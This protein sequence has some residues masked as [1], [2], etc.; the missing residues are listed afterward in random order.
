MVF[1]TKHF[2]KKNVTQPE[3]LKGHFPASI[4]LKQFFPDGFPREWKSSHKIFPAKCSS[5]H[6]TPYYPTDAARKKSCHEHSVQWYFQIPSQTDHPAGK[7][8][9]QDMTIREYKLNIRKISINLNSVRETTGRRKRTTAE[10]ASQLLQVL[11]TGLDCP[12]SSTAVTANVLWSCRP[13]GNWRTSD[14]SVG[15]E[16]TDATPREHYRIQT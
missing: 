16:D 6:Y 14:P 3:F 8:V 9:S 13:W 12:G 11:E 1:L 10:T 4:F 7:C 15:Q 5:L 2:P